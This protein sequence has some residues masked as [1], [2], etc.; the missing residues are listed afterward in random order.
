[1][2]RLVLNRRLGGSE[3]GGQGAGRDEAGRTRVSS[4]ARAGRSALGRA[5]KSPEGDALHARHLIS[6]L[7]GLQTAPGWPCVRGR[8]SL[9]G[10]RREGAGRGAGRASSEG[11]AASARGR[12]RRK[13]VSSRPVEASRSCLGRDTRSR[14][15]QRAACLLRERERERSKGVGVG[16]WTVR[17]GGE[18]LLLLGSRRRGLAPRSPR[19]T[20]PCTFQGSTRGQPTCDGDGSERETSVR[21]RVLYSANLDGQNR[22]KSRAGRGQ[23]GGAGARGRKAAMR[24]GRADVW[25]AERLPDRDGRRHGR[26][27]PR[28]RA[29]AEAA[30]A[31]GRVGD[32]RARPARAPDVARAR[33]RVTRHGPRGVARARDRARVVVARQDV[34]VRRR[35]HAD[36]RL[37]A[38]NEPGVCGGQA[39]EGSSQAQVSAVRGR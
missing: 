39:R 7:Q 20:C 30:R 13:G 14:D 8:A 1:M 38:R 26:R 35:D 32:A 27:R 10:E 29:R 21:P 28:R 31:A 23:T 11:E 22:Y 12:G 37:L 16:C 4:L 18:L 19:P 33:T 3:H 24:G 2:T 6:I 25:T 5:R 36:G 9:A 15:S 17:A 34:L